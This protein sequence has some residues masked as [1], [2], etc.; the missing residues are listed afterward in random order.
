MVATE[1]NG[2][3]NYYGKMVICQLTISNLSSSIVP[4]KCFFCKTLTTMF[5][6][7]TNTVYEIFTKF[8]Y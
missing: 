1:R 3:T 8:H 4:T 6:T 7:I 2:K 5:Q